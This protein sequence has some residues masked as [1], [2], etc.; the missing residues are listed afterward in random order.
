MKL[1]SRGLAIQAWARR[2]FDAGRRGL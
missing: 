1:H 2:S